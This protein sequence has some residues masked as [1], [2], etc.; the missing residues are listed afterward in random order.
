M[1]VMAISFI[2]QSLVVSIVG[3]NMGLSKDNFD[4]WLAFLRRKG[5]L[6]T[7]TAVV[8]HASYVANSDGK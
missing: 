5:I 2:A 1:V 6:K 3:I 4:V 8:P 7:T